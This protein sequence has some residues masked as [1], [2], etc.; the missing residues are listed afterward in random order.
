MHER[1]RDIDELA[2]A[3]QKGDIA[4]VTSLLQQHPDVL[5]SPDRDTRFP[6]P[7]SRLW[8]PLFLAATHGHGALVNMLLDMGANP[9]PFEV[10]GGYHPHAD[11]D[12]LSLVRERGHD[13][14]A[15]AHRRPPFG[16]ATGP[17]VDSANLHR[18]V[19]DGHVD[20]VRA[21]LDENPA[22][23]T[24]VDF[25]R[26][27]GAPLG[28]RREQPRDDAAAHRTRR[29]RGRAEW[30][31]SDAQRVSLFGFHRYWRMKRSRT[32][33]PVSWRTARNTRS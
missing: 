7:E 18:G 12:W 15:D 1:L 5:D 21:L 32:S 26:E 22:R 8:S 24:Q 17:A 20:R 28:G 29:A 23:V 27:H 6:Y 11:A 25:G 19:T 16:N 13:V 4:R 14:V 10:S 30:Q 3:C 31:R 33:S 9:V 2:K